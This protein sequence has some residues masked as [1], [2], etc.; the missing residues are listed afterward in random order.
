M[1]VLSIMKILFLFMAVL[2]TIS[3]LSRM[4]GKNGIPGKH[5]V[6]QAIGITGYIVCQWLV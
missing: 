3:N 6:Y 1:L 4:Y 2:F 5:F